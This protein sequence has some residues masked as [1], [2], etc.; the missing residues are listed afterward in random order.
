MVGAG[1]TGITIARLA[2]DAGYHVL[3]LERR[4]AVGGNI[5]DALHPSGI[6]YGLYGPHY[7]RT[8][9][10]RIWDFV[11]RF[12]VFRQFA[13]EVKTMVAGHLEDWPI[14]ADYLDRSFG[15]H[16][17][18]LVPIYHRADIG[19][20]EDACLAEL[21][22]RAYDDFVRDYTAK[23]WGSDP[24][25]LE[26]GLAGRFEIR[27][28]RPDGSTDRRL[29]RSTWQGVPADG[30]AA[31]AEAMLADTGPGRVEVHCSIDYLR[32]HKRVPAGPLT[33]FTG[34]IDEF[35]G[36]QFGRLRY[37]AQ[38]REH[39]WL[40]EPTIYPTVQTNIPNAAVPWIRV[41]EWRHMLPEQGDGTLLTNEYPYS[42]SDADAY[43]YPFPSAAD[44]ALYQ[45]YRKRAA[46]FPGLIFAGRLGEYRYL[47][48][49]Q[50]I[51]RA[52]KRFTVKIQP[53]L[54]G[55]PSE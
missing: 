11:N 44:R 54:E 14:T 53:R 51:A 3:V 47:D 46:A 49:D 37:R 25:D 13:A 52:M 7:F 12:A 30:Y 16:W 18:Q 29:K 50:A 6:R 43:E 45:R 36:F 4:A 17:L 5:R 28:K 23:Q 34:A 15:P 21:P 31:L 9:S 8:S 55:R 41:I 42:P 22:R 35:F 1:L 24:R 19:N 33:V 20:F 10:R 48:M 26:P 2:A 39:S 27:A 40:A 32:H 38:Q